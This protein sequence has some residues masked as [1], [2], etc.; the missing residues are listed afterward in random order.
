MLYRRDITT[1]EAVVL[2][3]KYARHTRKVVVGQVAFRINLT[4]MDF[5]VL[6]IKQS[7]SG[8]SKKK[9]NC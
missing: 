6:Q 8:P 1:C 7:K 2:A 9:H 3:Q 4:Y 5:L